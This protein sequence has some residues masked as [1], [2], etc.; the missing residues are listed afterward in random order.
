MQSPPPPPPRGSVPL[1][2][3][4]SGTPGTE[5]K[6]GSGV[7]Q[8]RF[9]VHKSKMRGETVGVSIL[10][11]RE[12][13]SLEPWCVGAYL[14]TSLT[15]R[16]T[17]LQRLPVHMVQTPALWPISSSRRITSR[18]QT[19]MGSAGPCELVQAALAHP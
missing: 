2:S 14:T 7:D 9:N 15:E 3:G 18:S 11:M 16:K 6:L 19:G 10:Y 8:N 12:S 13:T 17:D 5:R 4:C 1:G